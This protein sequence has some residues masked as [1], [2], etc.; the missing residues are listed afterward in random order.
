MYYFNFI[1]QQLV[2]DWEAS[3]EGSKEFSFTKVKWGSNFKI[4]FF[5]M[6]N[7]EEMQ[8]VAIDK[9]IHLKICFQY[10]EQ[11]LYPMICSWLVKGHS[12][13]LGTDPSSKLQPSNFFCA[14]EKRKSPPSRQNSY[15]HFNKLHMFNSN[16]FSDFRTV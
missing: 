2:R 15:D 6:G 3:V 14:T 11:Q 12:V 5:N 16:I 8:L 1:F 9:I 4:S 10:V 13:S 7:S